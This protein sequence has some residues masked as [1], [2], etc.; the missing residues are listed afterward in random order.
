MDRLHHYTVLH[1]TS[2][3]FLQRL[4]KDFRGHLLKTELK[5]LE[6]DFSVCYDA[7]Y[8]TISLYRFPQYSHLHYTAFHIHEQKK[9]ITSQYKLRYTIFTFM[10]NMNH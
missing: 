3:K 6:T 2:L 9:K 5:H 4:N 10:D 1:K 7:F 8:T